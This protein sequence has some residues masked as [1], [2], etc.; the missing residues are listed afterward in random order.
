MYARIVGTGSY[1]PERVVHNTDL[2]KIMDTSDQWIRDRTG[3]ERRHYAADGDT[4]DMAACG[5]ADH[6]CRARTF[7]RPDRLG[8][9][10]WTVF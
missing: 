7:R 2:E 9:T 3:I 1:L 5:A 8:T 10:I 6:R 4:V